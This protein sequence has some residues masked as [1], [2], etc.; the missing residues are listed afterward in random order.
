MFSN[1]GIPELVVV[2]LVVLI[3]FGGKKIPELGKNLGEAI[4]EVKK[5]IRGENK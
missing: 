5:A 4:N 1:I 3:L 2:A